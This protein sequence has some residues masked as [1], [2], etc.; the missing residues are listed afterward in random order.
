MYVERNADQA[1]RQLA[2][3]YPIVAITGPRQS[4]KTTLVRHLMTETPTPHLK[5]SISVNLPS[6][7][8]VAFSGNIPT[9]PSWMKSTAR[10]YFF[11]TSKPWSIATAGKGYSFSLDPNRSVCAITSLKP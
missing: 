1:P 7:I 10:R 6:R 5:I 3:R 11:H 2:H 4:G 9:V 8:P